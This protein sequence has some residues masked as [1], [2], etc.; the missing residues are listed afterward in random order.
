MGSD[1]IRLACQRND[2]EAY[3]SAIVLL[4]AGFDPNNRSSRG[5]NALMLAARAGNVDIVKLLIGHGVDPSVCDAQGC[6][7][8]HYA[9]EGGHVE[10]VY[11]LRDCKLDWGAKGEMSIHGRMLQDV[12]ALHLAAKHPDSS[13]LECL[14]DEKL[15]SDVDCVTGTRL[16]P[17][18]IAV[19]SQQPRNVAV[20][21]SKGANVNVLGD[22]LYGISPLHLAAG[23]GNQELVSEFLRHGCDVTIPNKDGLDCQMIALKYGFKDLAQM[24][25]EFAQKGVC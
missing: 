23:F 16:T 19:W 1:L 24:F 3:A 4:D 7:I 20:L 9:L 5:E 15:I 10:V 11:A 17:L 8:A 13:L 21:L 22:G 6:N 2:T 18:H 12:T 25:A 14:T